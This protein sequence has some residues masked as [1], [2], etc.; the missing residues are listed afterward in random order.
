MAP[1]K[2]SD[3]DGRECNMVMEVEGCMSGGKTSAMESGVVETEEAQRQSMERMNG[4][5]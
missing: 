1:V 3:E 4:L 2:A 5:N